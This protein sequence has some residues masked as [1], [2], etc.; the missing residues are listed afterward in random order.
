[1]GEAL[2]ISPSGTANSL[3]VLLN[4][5]ALPT[6]VPQGMLDAILERVSGD[7]KAEGGDINVILLKSLG[8]AI[9]K[10]MS[11]QSFI[12]LIRRCAHDR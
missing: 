8:E 10:R 11:K 6:E 12:E 4:K 2:G 9:I 3:Q 1:M 5:L 7:K